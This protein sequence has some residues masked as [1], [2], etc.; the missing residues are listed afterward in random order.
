M[1]SAVSVIQ[2]TDCSNNAKNNN[3]II[4]SVDGIYVYEL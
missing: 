3:A 1:T 4:A 2:T